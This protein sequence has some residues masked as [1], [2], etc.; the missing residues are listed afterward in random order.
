MTLQSNLKKIHVLYKEL[1][2]LRPI[3]KSAEQR[4]MEKLRLEWNFHSNH[5]EGNRLEYGE[6]KA[7]LL[8]DITAQG[9][10]LKDHI[11]MQAHNEALKYIEEVLKE[12]RPLTE[13]FIREIHQMILKEDYQTPA[14]TSE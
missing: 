5:I 10:P 7:L 8:F 12:E 6:T 9:K 11:E 1:E 14:I 13:Q 3:D 4:I 2:E